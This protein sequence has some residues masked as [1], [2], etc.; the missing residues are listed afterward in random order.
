MFKLPCYN[1]VKPGGE[2]AELQLTFLHLICFTLLQL[3]FKRSVFLGSSL[4]DGVRT[5]LTIRPHAL[6]RLILILTEEHFQITGDIKRGIHTLSLM[7]A[8]KH[9]C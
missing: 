1:V 5:Q 7:L 3:Q 9:T 6:E 4:L 2:P 8:I